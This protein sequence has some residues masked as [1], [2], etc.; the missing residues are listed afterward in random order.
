MKHCRWH[1]SPS[2][3]EV[4]NWLGLLREHKV[5]EPDRLSP[6]F[7]TDT[8]EVLIL[9]LANILWSVWKKETY[10]GIAVSR[11]LYRLLRK[12][13]GL[14]VKTAVEFFRQIRCA[15]TACVSSCYCYNIVWEFVSS[16]VVRRRLFGRR[17]QSIE[18]VKPLQLRQFA[19]F[20]TISGQ[21]FVGRK[22]VLFF[23]GGENENRPRFLIVCSFYISRQLAVARFVAAPDLLR[24]CV[25][26]GH[27]ESHGHDLRSPHT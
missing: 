23:L 25:I 26:L 13:I 17:I 5:A 9:K 21:F 15:K 4:T 8:G 19:D 22:G 6:F 12:V 20:V 27:F 1:I 3:I 2:K 10:L 24:S 18:E 7:L 14:A 16:G 11:W